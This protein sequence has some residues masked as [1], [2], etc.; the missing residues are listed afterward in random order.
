MEELSNFNAITIHY[1]RKI[2]SE[3]KEKSEPRASEI[4]IVIRRFDVKSIRVF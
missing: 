1:R 4:A 3:F 2:A